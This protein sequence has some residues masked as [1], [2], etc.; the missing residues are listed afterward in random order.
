MGHLYINYILCILLLG[1]LGAEAYLIVKRNRTV[2]LKGSGDF[3]S[4][5]LA[6][7]FAVL[8]FRLDE[9]TSVLAA[10]R[11]SLVLLALMGTLAVRRGFSEKGVVKLWRCIPWNQID[12]IVV[13]EYQLSKIVCTFSWGA[14]KC[15]LFFPSSWKASVLGILEEHA[16]KDMKASRVQKLCRV[17]SIPSLYLS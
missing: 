3:F 10:L 6:L 17:L 2:R 1:A 16:K 13:E 4:F 7:L 9:R 5:S 14:G 8:V 15:K 11:N 12:N